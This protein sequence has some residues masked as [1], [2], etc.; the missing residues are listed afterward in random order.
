MKRLNIFSTNE[1]DYSDKYYTAKGHY[2]DNKYDLNAGSGTNM[3]GYAN[4]Y[5]LDAI[6]NNINS[7][8][9]SF[10]KLKHPIWDILGEKLDIISN[11]KFSSY[12]PALTGS[13]SVDNSLKL[14]WWYWKNRGEKRTTVLVRENSYHSGSIT[15]WQM[16]K[17]QEFTTHFPQINFVTFFDDLETTI[18]QVGEENIAGILVD[19]TPWIGGLYSNTK[20]YWEEFQKTVDKYNLLLCVDEILTGIGRMGVWLHH[21]ELGLKPNLVTLGK[22]LSG[23][24]ANLTLTLLDKQITEGVKYEWLAIGNTRSTNTLGAVVANAVIEYMINNNTLD[25]I[26]TTII[27]HVNEVKKLFEDSNV[28]EEIFNEGTMLK[29]NMDEV[30]YLENSLDYN[31]LYHNLPDFFWYFPFYDSTEEEFSFV[32]E[33][34][35][36]ALTYL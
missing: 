35:R 6:N 25:Y 11:N 28:S 13:D 1:L 32:K 7:C 12:I 17:K 22:A 34:I 8:T 24:H 5:L 2:L 9:T 18:E 14:M 4:P 31:Q 26:N 21:Q 3:L 27:P 20:E 30:N 15:G 19:T 36:K 33:N 29:V 16:V 23:G 10:W